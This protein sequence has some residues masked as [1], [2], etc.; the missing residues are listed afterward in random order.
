MP[1]KSPTR[2]YVDP[3]K[4]GRKVGD[5]LRE[6]SGDYLPFFCWNC[7]HKITGGPI[8]C[9][10]CGA[11]GVG[12]TRY[13]APHAPHHPGAANAMHPSV[14]RYRFKAIIVTLIFCLLYSAGLAIYMFASGELNFDSGGI[15]IMSA[16]LAVLW[17]FWIIWLIWEYGGS[18]R[19]MR[20]AR[21]YNRTPGN[22]RIVCGLCGHYTDRRANYCSKC[23]CI[24]AK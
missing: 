18:G 17:L 21:E 1:G 14:L 20:Q 12:K 5:T 15:H 19:K 7:G 13:L 9:P 8:P 22:T 2:F 6:H 23:G 4:L 24:L 11:V 16:I 10:R 3:D